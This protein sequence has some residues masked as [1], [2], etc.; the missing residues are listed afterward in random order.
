[1]SRKHLHVVKSLVYLK[2]DRRIKQE[3]LDYFRISCLELI[4]QEICEKKVLG[5]V[6]ELGVYRGDFAASINEIFPNRKLYLFDTFEGFDIKDKNT[7]VKNGF[8]DAM[9]DFTD[10]S[11]EYVL[12]QMPISK[13]CI[14]RKGFFPETATGIEDNFSFVSIDTD[15]YEPIYAGLRYFYP[16]LSKGGY[17]MVHDFNNDE[18]KGARKAVCE[19]CEEINIGYVPIADIGGTVII[20]K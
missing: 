5:N 2:R 10:T 4:A 14:V 9:Q 18:Y 3:R 11:V 12:S 1:M 16:R 17:I 7:E 20:A 8:S 15:L 19:F 6:A 13:M